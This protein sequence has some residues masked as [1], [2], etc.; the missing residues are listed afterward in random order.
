MPRR[1]DSYYRA[2]PARFQSSELRT[3][4]SRAQWGIYRDLLDQLYINAGQIPNN[5]RHLVYLLM[6]DPLDL[7]VV[8]KVEHVYITPDNFIRHRVVDSE[9]ADLDRAREW[10]AEMGRRSAE[11]RSSE[12]PVERHV[13]RT[14]QRKVQRTVGHPQSVSQS[15][16]HSKRLAALTDTRY[17]DGLD[18]SRSDGAA[19]QPPVISPEARA[20]INAA[21]AAPDERRRK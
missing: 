10:G 12:R 11:K 19:D 18:G 9:L 16:S 1:D 14:V 8:L 4:L 21:I 13:Q 20:L 17:S 6:A 3:V 15:A 5:R 7:D 2:N